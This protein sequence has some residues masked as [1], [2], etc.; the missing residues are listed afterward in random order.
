MA[1]LR[2]DESS[3]GENWLDGGCLKVERQDLLRETEESRMTAVFGPSN[4]KEMGESE[5]GVRGGG[6]WCIQFWTC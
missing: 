6:R 1:S 2:Q 5:G 4:G 3:R